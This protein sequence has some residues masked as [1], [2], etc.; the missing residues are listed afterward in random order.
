MGHERWYINSSGSPIPVESQAVCKVAFSWKKSHSM[1]VLS[2][3]TNWRTAI[4][5]RYL[6][7]L[8]EA[9]TETQAAS[10]AARLHLPMR[11]DFRSQLKEPIDFLPP[12]PTEESESWQ[13]K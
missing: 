3:Y 4:A 6:E 1:I 13:K 9:R 7:H 8:H 10:P 5:V 2:L 12:E 11:R